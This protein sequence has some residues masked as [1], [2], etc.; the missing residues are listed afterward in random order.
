MTTN[1]MS[2]NVID[3]EIGFPCGASDGGRFYWLW[4]L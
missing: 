4:K 3:D 2:L 1:F